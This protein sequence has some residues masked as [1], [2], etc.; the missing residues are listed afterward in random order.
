MKTQTS[1]RLRALLH[2]SGALVLSGLVAGGSLFGLQFSNP[3]DTTVA[4]RGAAAAFSSVSA[5]IATS[6][7]VS[8]N[9]RRC[10]RYSP[11]RRC[12]IWPAGSSR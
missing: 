2:C 12:A 5:L 9:R 10:V 7:E 4:Y 3:V 6:S 1:R 11:T 8:R